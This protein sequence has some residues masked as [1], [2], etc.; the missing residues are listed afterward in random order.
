[1]T[2]WQDSWKEIPSEPAGSTGFE[3]RRDHGGLSR[4]RSNREYW[5]PWGTKRQSLLKGNEVPPLLERVHGGAEHDPPALGGIETR[6]IRD[7]DEATGWIAAQTADAG[8]RW[9]NT[10]EEEIEDLLPPVYPGR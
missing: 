3:D 6:A 1:M 4:F 7:I 8:E 2:E 10:V 5:S 9:F